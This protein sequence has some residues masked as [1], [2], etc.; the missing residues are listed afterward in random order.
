MAIESITRMPVFSTLLS[1]LNSAPA[2]A[3]RLRNEESGVNVDLVIKLLIN[4]C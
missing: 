1:L 3:K 4:N 2:L